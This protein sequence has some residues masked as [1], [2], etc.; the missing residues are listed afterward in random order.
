M[1]LLNLCCQLVEKIAAVDVET[2][3]RE[4][5]LTFGVMVVSQLL[6]EVATRN[7]G[8]GEF[9]AIGSLHKEGQRYFMDLVW[10]G[11]QGHLS[12]FISAL[13]SYHPGVTRDTI[14]PF[15]TKSAH[16]NIFS[17]MHLAFQSINHDFV[18]PFYSAYLIDRSLVLLQRCLRRRI[19]FLL[20]F[21]NCLHRPTMIF[22]F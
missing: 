17:F 21:C 12:E 15:V 13:K 19:N 18:S 6:S 20:G 22:P 7:S 9:G 11:V 2:L 10:K 8:F 4:D 1:F 14:R 16:P 5:K 3:T